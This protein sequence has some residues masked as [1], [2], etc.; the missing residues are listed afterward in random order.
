MPKEIKAPVS[1]I[2]LAHENTTLLKA[3][4][5][6]AQWAAEVLVIAINSEITSHQAKVIPRTSSILDFSEVRNWAMG[7]ATNEWVL[8]LDSDEELTPNAAK[9]ISPYLTRKDLQGIYLTRQDVFIGKTMHGGEAKIELLRLMRK[10]HAQFQGKTHEVAMVKGASIHIPAIIL[11]YPHQ[12]VSSFLEK[13]SRYS[14]RVALERK[15]QHKNFYLWELLLFPL[16]KFGWNY[17]LKAG[18]IDGWRGIVYALL[19]SIHS[20]AVRIFLYEQTHH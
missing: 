8:F 4:I 14:L 19:M 10:S 7:Q 12:S 17:I 18:F 20:A 11:H 2:I 9:I 5:A 3:A 6:S 16:A 13:I 15:E 1:V